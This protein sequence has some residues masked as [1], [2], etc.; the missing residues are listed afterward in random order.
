MANLN[1]I[2]INII[3]FKNFTNKLGRNLSWLFF[4]VFLLIIAAEIFEIQTSVKIIM[5]FRSEPQVAIKDQGV[6]IDFTK[7]DLVVNRIKNAQNFEPSNSVTVN[8]FDNSVSQ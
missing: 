7:Y 5:D 6:R 1:K 4:V 2:N 3:A 8:P